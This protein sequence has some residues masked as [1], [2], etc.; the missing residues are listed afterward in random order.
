MNRKKR[1]LAIFLVPVVVVIVV[2]GL[3]PLLAMIFS[4]I[5]TKMSGN[6]IDL[7]NHTVENR[8]VVLEN[9]MVEHWRS[10]YKEEET[11][12]NT[13]SDV[14]DE[15]EIDIQSFLKSD[16]AQLQYLEAVFPELVDSLQYN[17]TSGVFL[18]LANDQETQDRANYRGFFVRDSDPQNKTASNTD[19]LLERGSKRLS[20]NGSI[21]LDSAWTTDFTFEGSGRRASDDFFYVPYETAK[22]HVG[23]KMV[24]LGYWSKPFVLEDNSLDNHR[25]ITY[26]VPLRYGGTIYGVVGIEISISYLESYLTVSNLDSG[27]NAGYALA[28]KK[29]DGVYD[30][31]AGKGTLYDAVS[32]ESKSF[33]LI[34]QK[35]DTDI[36]KVRG[37]KVG[38]QNIYAVEKPLDLYS[39]NVPYS[40]TSWVLCGFVTEDSVYGMGNDIFRII[41]IAV[42]VSVLMAIIMVLV[43]TRYVTKPVYRLMESVRGGV[44]GIHRFK[45]SD[46]VEIDELHDVIENL[47]D[48]QKQIEGQIIEEKERY[49]IAVESSQDMFFTYNKKEQKLELVNTG[50]N[51]GTW[52]CK[53]HPEFLNNEYVHPADKSRL[54]KAARDADGRLY[55][56]FR[57][58]ADEGSDYE[59]MELKGTVISD[60]EGNTES[61][62]GCVHNINQRKLLEEAQQKEQIYDV[63]TSFYRQGYGLEAV[64][65]SRQTEFRGTMVMTDIEKF[66]RINEKYGLVFGDIVVQ[67]LAAIIIDIC[68]A[69]DVENA[70]FI[71]VGADQILLWFPGMDAYKA[72]GIVDRLRNDMRSLTNDNY[73]ELDLKAGITYTD[74]EKMT[75]QEIF[76]Q[77]RIALAVAKKKDRDH[78]VYQ[79]IPHG[80]MVDADSVRLCGIDSVDRLD[81]MSLSSIALNL[82][83]RGTEARVSM[84][85]LALKLE[86]KYQITNVIATRFTKEYMSNSRTYQWRSDGTGWEGIVHCAESDY[87]R[88]VARNSFQMMLALD[89]ESGD[90]PVYGEFVKGESGVVY[91]MMDNGQYSGSLFFIG[92]DGSMLSDDAEAKIFEEMM[93]IIQNRINMQRHDMS[94]QAKSDFLARMSH[95]IRT[96][97]NGIIGMTEVALRP[98]QTEEKRVECLKKIDS[99]S[100]YLLGILNDIL[101]MS[102]IESGKMKLVIDRCSIPDMM[103]N[104]VSIMDAK[105]NEKDITFEQNI[106]LL[107]EWFYGDELRLNQVLVN[108]LSN[109]VK[110][111][112]PGGHVDLTVREL[113]V[114]EKYS[115]I[116]FEVKDNGIGI[117]EGKQQLIFQRFEQADDSAKA[118]KQGTGL[119]LAISNRLVH[120]MDSDIK[121]TSKVGEG[122]CFSFTVRLERIADDNIIEKNDTERA[123]FSGRRVLAVEDNELNMEIIKM[124]LEERGM[125][126]EEAHDGQEAVQCVESASDGYYDLILMDIMMPVMDGLEA[127]RTIRLMDRQYCRTVPIVAM[128]ANAF[129]DDVR[130]SMAS[131]MNGHLSKPVNIGKLE[132]MLASVWSGK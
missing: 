38:K 30:V 73:L 32:R 66:S 54:F 6:V 79:D 81:Q 63:L 119:G 126:V 56:E 26:T 17:T 24:N 5:R 92:M 11:L 27:L 47:A 15:Q 128:S 121:L 10:I 94:A 2:Q 14:L 16:D 78:M 87:E 95:E 51:D 49:R 125:I 12:N 44:D 23:V 3:V 82:F 33:S 28:V 132:E 7:D 70:V 109:A 83:D 123:S 64:Q 104:I 25:M 114:D 48:A 111:S 41:C 97:M 22:E 71:R 59:W 34:Q 72:A 60:D 31:I 103:K 8:Q 4:G 35:D 45:V 40:D 129:D 1:L 124:I 106:S 13:L 21:S 57:L 118:R 101:D 86:E 55:V 131:G 84:D 99:A 42:V 108:L 62:V 74:N 77:T 36:A 18:I 116:Y 113:P 67:K 122:S 53:A 130:R 69:A 50:E 112:N 65:E 80:D 20:Q 46:I 9:D 68:N 102:K 52:D 90:D 120:M 107:H 61:I 39:S 117:P 100:G 93:S 96:P 89:Q 43:L 115:D 105:M 75:A 37:A 88:F 98:G 58:R 85:M 29:S 19:L 127:A 91:H 76:D 110:Y